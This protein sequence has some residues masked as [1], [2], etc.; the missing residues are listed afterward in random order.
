MAK[1]LVVDEDGRARQRHARLGG[2]LQWERTR[3]GGERQR[4]QWSIDDG[5]GRERWQWWTTT[6]ADDNGMQDQGQQAATR[7]DKSRWQEM[8]ETAERQ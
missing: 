5:C 1:T 2:G 8:V 6:V 7:K 4:R 3:A